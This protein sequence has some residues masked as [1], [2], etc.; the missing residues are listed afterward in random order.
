M[1]R[2]DSVR[3]VR[4]QLNDFYQEHREKWA[5]CEAWVRV[6]FGFCWVNGKRRENCFLF[7][8]FA[9]I[10]TTVPASV[11]PF[12]PG[13]SPGQG[14]KDLKACSDAGLF[15]FKAR[16]VKRAVISLSRIAALSTTV[17]LKDCTLYFLFGH[18]LHFI[19]GFSQTLL[20]H[21]LQQ[22]TEYP[23]RPCEFCQRVAK[24]SVLPLNKLLNMD[25]FWSVE[26]LARV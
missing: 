2:S 19:L 25:T 21:S 12:V 24:M 18:T 20:T 16:V 8:I 7:F 5:F 15:H 10:I 13:S 22:A 6:E 9:A 11:N 14:A 26:R 3:R 4:E 1:P 23:F 17:I